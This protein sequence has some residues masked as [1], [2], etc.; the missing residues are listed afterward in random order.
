MG[1]ERGHLSVFLGDLFR[2]RA[3]CLRIMSPLSPVPLDGGKAAILRPNASAQMETHSVQEDQAPLRPRGAASDAVGPPHR[4]PTRRR[5]IRR[6][7]VRGR[8]RGRTEL[9]PPP[10]SPD[11]ALSRTRQFSRVSTAVTSRSRTS[12]GDRHGDEGSP[13]YALSSSTPLEH[14]ANPKWA[15]A[16]TARFRSRGTPLS[17]ELA[18]QIPM[19]RRVRRQR[20]LAVDHIPLLASRSESAAAARARPERA[21]RARTGLMP[22]AGLQTPQNIRTTIEPV[23]NC[24]ARDQRKMAHSRAC[25]ASV[26]HIICSHRSPGPAEA[27]RWGYE[28]WSLGIGGAKVGSHASFPI[29]PFASSTHAVHSDLP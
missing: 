14:A 6:G 4:C 7:P 22:N 20:Q 26:A 16:S 3:D 27:A 2:D 5:S 18:R 28:R 13:K 9:R 24:C 21:R 15:P 19:S 10:R 25:K 11:A 17:D 29:I 12:S 1:H 23:A 8:D